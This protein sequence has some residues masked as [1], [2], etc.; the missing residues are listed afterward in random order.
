MTPDMSL[1]QFRTACSVS[2]DLATDL[3][4]GKGELGTHPFKIRSTAK[5]F[6]NHVCVELRL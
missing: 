1:G 6:Y 3:L 5:G 4:T 2:V